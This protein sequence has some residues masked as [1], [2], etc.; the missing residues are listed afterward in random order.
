MGWRSEH[1]DLTGIFAY[2]ER[3]R[4]EKKVLLLTSNFHLS[5]K[6]GNN[7]E[8]EGDYKERVG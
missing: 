6:R 4:G 5:N 3:G 2:R 1:K 7:V 8:T